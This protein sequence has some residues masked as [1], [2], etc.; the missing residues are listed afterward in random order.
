MPSVRRMSG[1]KN[2]GT[3]PKLLHKFLRQ[4]R[5]F[6]CAFLVLWSFNGSTASLLFGYSAP[7]WTFSA[8]RCATPWNCFARSIAARSPAATH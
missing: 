3:D 5:F 6:A 8:I 1:P 7:F 2:R 4:S